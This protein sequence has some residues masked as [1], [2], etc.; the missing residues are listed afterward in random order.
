MKMFKNK[1]VKSFEIVY[2]GTWYYVE[3]FTE[4]KIEI[5]TEN[6]KTID[7]KIISYLVHYISAEGFLDG[8]INK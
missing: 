3:I 6:K 8:I 1:P 2:L 5:F 4:N 7:G